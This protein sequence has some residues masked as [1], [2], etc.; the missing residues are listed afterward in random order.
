MIAGT[1]S[2]E[3]RTHERGAASQRSHDLH[4]AE[5]REAGAVAELA[6]EQEETRAAAAEEQR[7]IDEE[8]SRLH[9]QRDA[10]AQKVPR[11]LLA[12]YDRIH[13]RRR[14]QTV[15]PLRGLS[16]GHCDVA[17]PLQ[18]R[19]EMVTRGTMEMCEGCGV[20]LYAPD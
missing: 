20:L 10:A 12:R 8:L 4:E 17:I 3:L 2:V 15:Y 9:A 6:R 18:R 14:T 5:A 16:C 1:A 11:A 13:G 19:N 7:T